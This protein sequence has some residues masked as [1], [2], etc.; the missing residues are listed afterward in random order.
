MTTICPV[1]GEGV[2]HRKVEDTVITH[3]GKVGLYQMHFDVCSSCK[4]E[5][6]GQEA[7]ERNK[8]AVLAFRAIVE[9][10]AT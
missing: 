3:L 1:C 5:V 10:T 7:S 4:S 6:A 2:L 9:K 8:N